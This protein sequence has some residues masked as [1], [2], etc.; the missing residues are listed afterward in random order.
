MKYYREAE[1]VSGMSFG[2]AAKPVPK[3][4]VSE[5]FR[6]VVESF[7]RRRIFQKTVNELSELDNHIL[8]DIG[9]DRSQIMSTAR[10]SVYDS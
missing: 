2:H 3:M 5:M 10:R 8:K 4:G 9:I 6:L 1:V 7:N